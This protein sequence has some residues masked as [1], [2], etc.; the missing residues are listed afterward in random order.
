M[1]STNTSGS[2]TSDTSRPRCSSGCSASLA[3]ISASSRRQASR[4]ARLLRIIAAVGAIQVTAALLG[5]STNVGL[6]LAVSIGAYLGGLQ[7]L[8]E[9]N[10]VACVLLA[11]G[12]IAYVNR[13][14]GLRLVQRGVKTWETLRRNP[15]LLTFSVMIYGAS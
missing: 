14:L 11:F 5:L 13:Q 10:L 3:G 8:Y 15:D 2:G 6:M 4:S 7:G 9:A 1:S 12:A